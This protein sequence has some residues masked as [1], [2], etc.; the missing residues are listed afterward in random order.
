MR[1]S[2]HRIRLR[3]SGTVV[4]AGLLLAPAAHAD[5]A[6]LRPDGSIL[7]V[8]TIEDAG[9]VQ[10]IAAN[11]RPDGSLDPAYGENGALRRL[12]PGARLAVLPDGQARVL[13]RDTDCS[14]PF[15][16]CDDSVRLDRYDA[17]GRVVDTNTLLTDDRADALEV[18]PA[19]A[20]VLALA[21]EDD[22]P[23]LYRVDAANVPAF[24]AT[25]LD[26]LPWYATRVLALGADALVVGT[27][28]VLRLG[29]DGLP[30]AGYG[31]DGRVDTGSVSP[32]AAAPLPG[33]AVAVAGTIAPE[34][35]A[36]VVRIGAGGQIDEDF[37]G[38]GRAEVDAGD[39]RPID[40]VE[41]AADGDGMLVAGTTPGPED[42][43]V[44]RLT[45]AG[46]LDSSYGTGGRAI[47]DFDGRDDTLT[48]LVALPGGGAVAI[49]TSRPTDGGAVELA[50]ARY[51]AGGT[52]DPAF[53]DGGLARIPID[54][55]PPE[56][57][58]VQA[59]EPYAVTGRSI[60]LQA[61]SPEAAAVVECTVG[62]PALPCRS[63]VTFGPLDHGQ[64]SLTITATDAD[65]NQ[66]L[67][68][69]RFFVPPDTAAGAGPPAASN[70]TTAAFS[71]SSATGSSFS[72]FEC[73]LDGAEWARCTSPWAVAGLAE[74]EH[75]AE[76][77]QV[78][79]VGDPDVAPPGQLPELDPVRFQWRVDLHAPVTSV[80]SAPPARTVGRTATV[81]FTSDDPGARTECRLDGG[82]WQACASPVTLSGLDVGAHALAIRSVDAAGNRE[83]SGP[84]VRWEVAAAD[85]AMTQAQRRAAAAAGLS[86]RRLRSRRPLR[87]GLR[88]E[89]RSAVDA[90][91]AHASRRPDD[92]LASP[93]PPRPARRPDPRL[94]PLEAAAPLPACRPGAGP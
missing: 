38:D 34:E 50:L 39:G 22:V 91:G 43:V 29:D 9:F 8:V 6:G 83:A 35:T 46:A 89:V 54:V 30:D 52:L 63:P 86:L 2:V 12:L 5:T 71:F 3:L 73:R 92:R 36:G 72:W 62:G 13:G 17:D 53:G 11:V 61:S 80:I 56:L 74:G 15:G 90:L 16:S 1:A 20:G 79:Q 81:T 44:V 93:R 58:V 47:A 10:Q 87:A 25:T 27:G 49:G 18:T 26:S 19:G 76:V 32:R 82:D 21:S 69:R 55:V 40:Q 48:G 24:P 57:E 78:A 4:A 67:D 66:R 23:V 84:V 33:G 31:E 94:A 88:L 75:A 37:A 60:T 28:G 68:R 14:E 41:I 45:S 70:S 77:R 7:A 42:F 64:Y 51:D 85:P 59:P 65:G